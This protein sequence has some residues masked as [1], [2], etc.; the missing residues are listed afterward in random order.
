MDDPSADRLD[1]TTEIKK[2]RE[3][4]L[5]T[6]ENPHNEPQ[7]LS[8]IDAGNYGVVRVVNYPSAQVV[9][10]IY[11]PREAR[12]EIIETVDYAHDPDIADASYAGGESG[13]R[14]V[15]DIVSI[16]AVAHHPHLINMHISLPIMSPGS[17]FIV[18]IGAT[19]LAVIPV[20]S[21]TVSDDGKYIVGNCGHQ[22]L[23]AV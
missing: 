17:S 6:Q 12:S 8:E 1:K 22:C 10:V 20:D 23:G 19:P 5:Q 3:D 11:Y 4:E 9:K 14:S 13:M 18:D 2:D 16:S 15:R 7:I 21:I